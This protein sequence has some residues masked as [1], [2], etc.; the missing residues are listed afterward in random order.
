MIWRRQKAARGYGNIY[1]PNAGAM[2]IHVQRE[3]GLANRTIVLSPRKVRWLRRTAIAAGIAFVIIAAS[4]VFLAAQAARVPLLTRQLQRLQHDA[5]RID[6][7]QAALTELEG[8][9]EQVQKMLGA[10]GTSP[11]STATAAAPTTPPSTSTAPVGTP[12]DASSQ[13]ASER[14]ATAAHTAPAAT[15]PST[16]AAAR[17]E[18]TTTPS[19][20]PPDSR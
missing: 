3:S 6:T 20:T 18:S 15:A 10:A 11:G 12:R 5:R 2:I 7:L 8:R 17:A 13:P 4:W 19:P 14:P 9:Y 1:T 16:G